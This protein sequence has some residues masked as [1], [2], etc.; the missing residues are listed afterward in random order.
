MAKQSVKIDGVQYKSRT[1]AAKAMVAAGKT[2]AEAA[3]ATGMTYQTVYANTKGA[4]KVNKRR[5][6]YRV[7]AM[8]KSGNRTSGEI[9]KKTGL[10]VSA[11]VALLKKN[12]IAI[13]TKKAKVAAK[14][15]KAGKTPKAIRQKV[16]KPENLIN[17]PE[18]I[19]EVPLTPAQ[20]TAE[21]E[22]ADEIPTDDAAAEAAAKA[23]MAVAE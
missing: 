12:S 6:K 14:T 13:V 17:I 1:E 4:E 22:L 8:G 7:L 9:A 18:P 5:A 15:A 11:V 3:A 16:T 19:D 10:S 2:L 21:E 20:V 23:D